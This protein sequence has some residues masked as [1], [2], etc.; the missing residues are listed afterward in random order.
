MFANPLLLEYTKKGSQP[1]K[2]AKGLLGDE[3]QLLGHLPEQPRQTSTKTMPDLQTSPKDA[4][5]KPL[6]IPRKTNKYRRSPGALPRNNSDDNSTNISPS[7]F[8]TGAR[9][10]RNPA[11]VATVSDG[12]ELTPEP[13]RQMTSDTVYIADLPNKEAIKAPDL[14]L[15]KDKYIKNLESQLLDWGTWRRGLIGQLKPYAELED[16]VSSG[17]A[18]YK[19]MQMTFKEAKDTFTRLTVGKT[20]L[21]LKDRVCPPHK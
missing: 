17:T 16:V 21:G 18:D 1:V 3:K 19:I 4:I 10:H 9:S 8:M 14:A 11:K 2:S 13:K 7:T 5:C 12:H 20:K 6:R 15:A